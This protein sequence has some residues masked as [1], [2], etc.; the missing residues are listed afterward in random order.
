MDQLLDCCYAAAGK[1][2]LLR[3]LTLVYLHGVERGVCCLPY[4]IIK[5]MKCGVVFYDE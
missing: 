4:A 3:S 2:I 5:R 1:L